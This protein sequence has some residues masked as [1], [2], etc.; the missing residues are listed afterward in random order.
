MNEMNLTKVQVE[1]LL[2]IKNTKREKTITEAARHFDCSKVNAKKIMDRM[3]ILGIFYKD[4][5]QYN[6]TAIGE[7]YAKDYSKMLDDARIFTKN[8]AKI[9]GENLEKIAGEL[10]HIQNLKDTIEKY[11]GRRRKIDKLG[12]KVKNEDF[13]KIYSKDSCDI[14]MIIYKISH[15]NLGSFL[16]NSMAMMGFEQ[17]VQIVADKEDYILLKTRLVERAQN[18]YHKKAMA[19]NLFYEDE[20]AEHKIDSE[21]RSFKVPLKIIK[22]WN[23][24]G[25]GVLQASINLTLKAQIGFGSHVEK[26]NFVFSVNLH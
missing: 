15:N 12:N 9:E 22:F 17:K 20:K 7:K 25:N 4:L 10:I 6:L 5:N 26:A 19:V 23:N 1:Y 13:L 8:L 14:S 11:A 21:D 16:D 2:F 3:L 18:G 24:L